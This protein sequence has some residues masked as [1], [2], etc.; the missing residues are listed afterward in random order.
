MCAL[1]SHLWHM[2]GG[3]GWWTAETCCNSYSL[4]SCMC[5]TT[6]KLI[7]RVTI[8]SRLPAVDQLIPSLLNA[9]LH[10]LSMCGLFV[11]CVLVNGCKLILHMCIGYVRWCMQQHGGAVCLL[12]W[13]S[14]WP[15][16]SRARRRWGGPSPNIN[17]NLY[18]VG[19]SP[20]GASA[21]THRYTCTYYM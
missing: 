20:P 9:G 12:L 2:L 10:C 21:H 1:V 8:A 19:A 16:M 4:P 6:K 11:D 3:L 18:T 15:L 5:A 17:K 7:Q 13:G 14:N